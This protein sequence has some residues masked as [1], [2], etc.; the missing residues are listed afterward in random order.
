MSKPDICADPWH[1]T[2]F[3]SSI[4]SAARLVPLSVCPGTTAGE[5]FVKAASK[6][7][8]NNANEVLVGKR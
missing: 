7:T 8:V 2:Q 3:F 1:E 6:E 4:D 5:K